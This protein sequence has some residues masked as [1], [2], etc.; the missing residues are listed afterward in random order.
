MVVFISIFKAQSETEFE[1]PVGGVG[2]LSGI[3]THGQCPVEWAGQGRRP[4]ELGV[5]LWVYS[6]QLS[7]NPNLR[8]GRL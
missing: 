5:M 3:V 2:Q 6:L 1:I 8:R 7:H 4:Y